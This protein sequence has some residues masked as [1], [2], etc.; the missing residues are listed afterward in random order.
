MAGPGKQFSTLYFTERKI[1]IRPLLASS[2]LLAWALA[3][4][5]T[6]TAYR[7]SIDTWR[8]Q[9]D[10]KIRAADGPLSAIGLYW[11]RPGSNQLGAFPSNEIVLPSDVAPPRAGTIDV[12][13]KDI[14]FQAAPEVAAS[15]DG[16][17]VKR[18]ALDQEGKGSRTHF[19]IG[20][21]KL[22]VVGRDL[23]LAVRVTDPESPARRD[24]TGQ[25]W[26][27]VDE[28]WKV[29]GH[30]VPFATPKTLVYEAATGGTRKGISPGYVSFE[31]GG[32]TYKLDVQESGGGY[33]A[34]FFDGTTGKSSYA[35]GRVVPIEKGA[36]DVV[37]LDFNKAYNMPCAV[38]AYFNCQ[39]APEQNH[40]TALAIEAGEKKPALKVQRVASAPAYLK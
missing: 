35:G 17:E 34:F 10:A 18:I 29:A 2:L 28:N 19:N 40:L 39:I 9:A 31:R 23:G 3:S 16:K 14:T 24:F 32:K 30:F 27:A 37:S 36:G 11:L 7:T 38:S 20:R 25:Q 15:L 33:I 1:M 8:A 6:D 12:A 22:A 21:V 4:A 5:A 26:F 13:G